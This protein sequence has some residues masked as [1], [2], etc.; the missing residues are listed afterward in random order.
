MEKQIDY[1]IIIPVYY[2]EGSLKLTYRNLIELVIQ[3]NSNLSC[4]IIFVDDGSKDN[5]FKELLEIKNENTALV[6]LI[7]LSRNFG[8]G[9]AWR[10]G[11]RLAKGK[12]MICISAD[13]Q[14]PPELINDM[15]K[16]HFEDN[17]EIV[18]CVRDSRDETFYRRSTS[19]IFYSFIKKM[20]F[21]NMPIGGFDYFLISRRVVEIVLKYQEAN[22]FFQGQLLW[23]GFNIKFI[24]YKRLKRRIGKSRWTYGKKS[25]MLIDGVLAYSHSPL[26]ILS[27]LGSIIAI[28]GFLVALWLIIA[29]LMGTTLISEWVLI[30]ISIVVL[31]GI[32]MLMLGMIGEYLLRTLDQVKN[33]PPYIIDKIYD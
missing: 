30:V 3:K 7:K 8:Q 21:S 12:C 19:K 2:N 17:F 23:T 1:S 32:Q 5:S 31:S 20:S 33:R 18:A 22:P 10:A 13:L 28:L 15:L 9:K 24:P 4:E 16:A 26:R 11:L 29:K 27:I 25:K 6:K 14:D